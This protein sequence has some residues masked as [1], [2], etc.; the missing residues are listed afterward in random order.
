MKHTEQSIFCKDTE[1]APL[2][3]N[4]PI[5]EATDYRK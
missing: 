4:I 1:V 3:K 2:L 5:F